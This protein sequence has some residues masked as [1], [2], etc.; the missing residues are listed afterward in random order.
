MYYIKN[1][2][3]RQ[4][5]NK[6]S[7]VYSVAYLKNSLRSHTITDASPSIVVRRTLKQVFIYEYLFEL[8]LNT[9]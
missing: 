6:D 8:C 3:K 9:N 4:T 7:F 2:K 5:S 1:I